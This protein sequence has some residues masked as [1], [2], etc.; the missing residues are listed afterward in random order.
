MAAAGGGHTLSRW[1]GMPV[2]V[3]GAQGFVGSWLLRRRLEEGGRGGALLEEGARVVTLRRDT[4]PYSHFRTAGLAQ[5]CI[6]V[7]ADLTDY[8]GLMQALGDHDVKA[9][10]HLGAQT[11]VG[12]ANRSP[13][14][15]FE[16]NIRGTYTLLE[17]CRNIGVL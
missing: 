13:F 8:D 5:R 1:R 11:I 6:D 17:A 15:T 16:T 7:D 2:L 14:P 10:F 3:T 4:E 9:V 12:T